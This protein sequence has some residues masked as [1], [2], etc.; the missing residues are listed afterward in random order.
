MNSLGNGKKRFTKDVKLKL[1][2][3][4]QTWHRGGVEEIGKTNNLSQILYLFAFNAYAN[5]I[6]I[7]FIITNMQI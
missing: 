2:P 4:V 7:F 5:S 6:R 3:R 1:E